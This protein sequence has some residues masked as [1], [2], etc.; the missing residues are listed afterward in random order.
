MLVYAIQLH[1]INETALDIFFTCEE[2]GND[3]CFVRV[4]GLMYDMELGGRI[5]SI[6]GMLRRRM[7]MKVSYL[8]SINVVLF[9][10]INNGTVLPSN[11]ENAA[12][13]NGC[14]VF[15]SGI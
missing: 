12:F 8:E 14:P 3:Q 7:P 10:P 15:D 2:D 6:D 13:I 9:I 4:V 1:L 5:C 11:L